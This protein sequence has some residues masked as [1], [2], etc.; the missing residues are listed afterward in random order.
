[1]NSRLVETFLCWRIVRYA[2]ASIAASIA[3][4]GLFLGLLEA[5]LPA[6]LSAA[7]GYCTGV[8]VHWMISSRMV[9]HDRLDIA[10]YP[11]FRQFWAFFLSAFI[12]L[13][14]TIA[15]VSL[16]Q[17]WGVDPRLGKLAAMAA[18]FA[19]VFLVRLLL[20]FRRR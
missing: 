12:G 2:G 8:L 7:S 18:S 1:M 17:D 16:A 3:D 19:S 4:L 11:R 14:L 6:T 13:G 5:G 15:I 9:F 10:G 20:V